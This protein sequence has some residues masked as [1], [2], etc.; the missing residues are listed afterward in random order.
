[1]PLE[2]ERKFLLDPAHLPDLGPG[3]RMEQGYLSHKPQVRFR[4]IGSEVV[5]CLKSFIDKMTQMEM[6]FSRKIL[7]AEE[8]RFLRK[9]AMYP[10]LIKV[11]HRVSYA[12][13]VWEVDV[14]EGANAGLVT[15]DVEI[16]DVNYPI[17]F[18]DWVDPEANIKH[19]KRYTNF[20]L[21]KHPFSQW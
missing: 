7:D 8:L 12:D 6:E 20:S 14:Y 19:V 1:M 13:L 16:P 5:L 9:M 17:T 11:R 21:T 4:I 10:P 2:I 15:V 3:V 18:P